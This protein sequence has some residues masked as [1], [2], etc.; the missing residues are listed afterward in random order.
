MN[1]RWLTVPWFFCKHA[2]SSAVALGAIAAL[3]YVTHLLGIEDGHRFFGLIRAEWFFDL[4]D[5][6]TLSLF[7]GWGLVAANRVFREAIND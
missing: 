2:I 7:V 4:L 6:G 1:P 5:F 3:Q